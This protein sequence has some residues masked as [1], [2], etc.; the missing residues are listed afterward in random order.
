[1][2]RVLLFLLPAFLGGLAVRFRPNLWQVWAAA[3]VAGLIAFL[4]NWIGGWQAGNAAVVTIVA[5]GLGALG[6]EIFQGLVGGLQGFLNRHIGAIVVAS[7]VLIL[8]LFLGVDRAAEIV[9]TGALIWLLWRA[10]SPR[11]NRRR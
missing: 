3:A 10:F 5:L 7:A 2:G 4:G 8:P 6:R 9:V 1:M 11:R